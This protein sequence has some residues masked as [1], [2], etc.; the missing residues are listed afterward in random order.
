MINNS[1]SILK[2]FDNLDDG[3]IIVDLQLRVQFINST[4]KD[5]LG[6][7]DYSFL[8]SELEIIYHITNELYQPILKNQLNTILHSRTKVVDNVLLTNQNNREFL[9]QQTLCPLIED[10]HCTGF[11]LIIRKQQE[12]NNDPIKK[13]KTY[14]SDS[15]AQSSHHQTSKQFYNLAEKSPDI[16][17]I[18]DVQKRTV[19]YFNRSELFGYDCKQ[20]EAPEG[21]IEIVHPEDLKK[22]QAH[23]N[24]FIKTSL[25]TESIEYRIK[26][27]ND[28]YEWVLNRHSILEKTEDG[29]PLLILLNITIITDRKSQEQA[30]KTSEKRLLELIENTQDLIWSIDTDYNFTILNSAFKN[31]MKNNYK[32]IVNIGDNLLDTLPEKINIEWLM[33]H[34]KSLLGENFSTEVK[35][36]KK[37]HEHPFEFEFHAIKNENEEVTAVFVNAKDI[38]SRK[39]IQNDIIRTNFELD[40][41]VYRSS[42]DLRAPLRSILG[43]IQ[44]IRNET[45]NE[46]RNKY[47]ELIDKSINKLDAFIIDLTNF[48]R[49]SRLEV[50]KELINFQEIIDQCLE[51]LQYMEYAKRIK[52]GIHIQGQTNYYSDPSRLGIIFQNLLSNAFK[53]CNPRAEESWVK[54]TIINTS[55][56]CSIAVEDN[57]L[58]IKDQY[59]NQIFNMFFRATNDSYGSGLGLYITKQVVEKLDGLISVSSSSGIGTTFNIKLNT[60]NKQVNN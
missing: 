29:A 47:F 42:H 6:L 57:G 18:I 10:N 31:W 8:G 49:N 55:S 25:E 38:T 22:V 52:V 15:N 44:V 2:V 60:K 1:Q 51:N 50:K 32:T 35:L 14:L 36:F 58:G 5:I 28:A 56:H 21:W 48:S 41:F 17:Y 37:K 23:W 3:V 46:Q 4:A 34:K 20:L 9:L 43:L 11:Q 39:K 54:I 26:K 19:V 24:K 59:L 13:S 27:K 45:S 40:S 7:D 12:A 16:I 53:Y 30:L 33:L